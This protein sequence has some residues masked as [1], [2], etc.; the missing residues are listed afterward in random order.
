[1]QSKSLGEQLYDIEFPKFVEV[2]PWNRR[3]FATRNDIILMETGRT[4][5]R[6]I[7]KE[8]QEFYEERAKRDNRVRK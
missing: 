6:L 5:W 1:M 7:T 3:M 4:P 8:S 2:I